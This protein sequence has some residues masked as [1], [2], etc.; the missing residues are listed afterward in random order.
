MINYSRKNTAPGDMF[1]SGT[2]VILVYKVGHKRVSYFLFSN[3][4]SSRASKS[5]TKTDYGVPKY[6]ERVR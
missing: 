3:F 6:F 5:Y 4:F 1:K 2:D